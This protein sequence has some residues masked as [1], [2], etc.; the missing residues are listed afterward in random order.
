MSD[1]EIF[2]AIDRTDIPK[3][4]DLGKLP[5]YNSKEN[6]TALYGK[7][8]GHCAGCEEHFQDRHLEVD[9][10]IARSKAGQIIW[11]ISNCYAV[12][13]IVSRAIADGASHEIPAP[14]SL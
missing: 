2:E 9:H 7:Q 8:K 4:T 13:A 12:V 1:A 10:I 3:R 11:T 6:R 5:R 14:V